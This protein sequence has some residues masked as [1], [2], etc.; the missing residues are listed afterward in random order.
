M[1]KFVQNVRF[2]IVFCMGHDV[3]SSNRLM[4]A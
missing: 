2:H 3:M 1:F 4:K